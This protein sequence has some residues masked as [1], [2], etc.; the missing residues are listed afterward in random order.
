MKLI[1]GK[2][3]GG[4]VDQEIQYRRGQIT[5]LTG[6]RRRHRKYKHTQLKI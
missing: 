4:M 1:T 2:E 3:G 5:W 6:A